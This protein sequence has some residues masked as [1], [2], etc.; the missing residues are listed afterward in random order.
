MI[1]HNIL[2]QFWRGIY[3]KYIAKMTKLDARQ[4]EYIVREKASKGKSSVVISQALGISKRRV[5]QVYRYYTDNGCIPS[6]A[7]PG[8]KKGDEL[9]EDEVNLIL[10]SYSKYLVNALYLQHMIRADTGININHNRI[11]RVMNAS[12]LSSGAGRR[13][14]KRNWIRYER[15]HSNELWHTDWH[16]IKDPRWKGLWLI[17]YE[18]DSSRF[19]T[20]YGVFP[21]LTSEYSVKVLKEAIARYGRPDVMLSDHGSTFYAIESV[22]REKG[23]SEFEKYL[24]KM[25][26]RF[27]LGRVDHPQTNGKLEKFHDIF[28]KKVKYFGSIDGF[29]IWYN[30]TRPHGALDLDTPLHAYI[31]RKEKRESLMDPSIMEN[32]VIS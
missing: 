25:K 26:I 10:N 17:T 15:E 4:M 5:D 20:G 13:W 1:K 23:L 22:A 14:K 16:Q 27:I 30:C 7:M 28:E 12:G 32:W 9:T 6:L 2:G 3:R 29:F 31:S 8:R 18:D 11:Q 21:T 19:V 24:L